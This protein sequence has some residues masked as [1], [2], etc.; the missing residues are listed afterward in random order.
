MKRL[1]V[2]SIDVRLEIWDT[3]GQERFRTVTKSYYDRAMGV[4]LVYDCTDERS[5]SDIRNWVKQIENHARP[6]IVKILVSNKSDLPDKKIDIDTGKALAKE[7]DME[8][9]ETSAKLNMNVE[10]VFSLITEQI[11][12]KNLSERPQQQNSV[13]IN[14][15]NHQLSSKK[16][17]C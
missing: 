7:L 9:V 17:C 11:I 1:N 14:E 4:V 16:K 8:F 13:M 3:S 6:D 10:K 2:K 15:N 12:T 5:F